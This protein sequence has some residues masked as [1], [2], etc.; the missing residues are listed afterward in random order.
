MTVLRTDPDTT[1]ALVVA[2]SDAD[3]R[4]ILKSR[5]GTGTLSFRVQNQDNTEFV[6]GDV[7]G[8]A[9]SNNATLFNA[10]AITNL[11]GTGGT[12]DALWVMKVS[13]GSGT[14]FEADKD[15]WTF[16][17][18]NS[19]E[20]IVI[21]DTL[22]LTMVLNEGVVTNPVAIAE[23]MGEYVSPNG[24]YNPTTPPGTVNVTYMNTSDTPFKFGKQINS[25]H[26][27][28]NY[29][30][31]AYNP[32]LVRLHD[33][34]PASNADDG[35]CFWAR[36]AQAGPHQYDKAR[37]DE[38]IQAN[39]GCPKNLLMY[40]TPKWAVSEANKQDVRNRY[41][42]ENQYGQISG[43]TRYPSY[44]YSGH[45]AEDWEN[46]LGDY[47]RWIYRPVNELGPGGE[48]G[49]GYTPEQIP[50][51]EGDNEQKF[52][53]REPNST[54]RWWDFPFAPNPP[55]SFNNMPMTEM[56]KKLRVMRS[57]APAEVQIWCGGW[58]GDYTGKTI[59]N[60][61]SNIEWSFFQALMLTSDGAGGLAIDHVDG[62]PFHPYMYN[63]DPGR[64]LQELRGYREQ[65]EYL[66]VY[67]NRPELANLPIYAN[68]TGHENTSGV[69][70]NYGTGSWAIDNMPTGS[71]PLGG[72]D[73]LA[74]NM[75]LSTMY[76]AI[77]ASRMKVHGITH[78]KDSPNTTTNGTSNGRQTYGCPSE[79]QTLINMINQLNQLDGE[80]IR[81]G[82]EI[83]STNLGGAQAL[84][85]ECESGLILEQAL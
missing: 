72:Y 84:W 45:E 5:L 13:N 20:A 10:V 35:G 15:C 3:R 83:N 46:S 68:E 21:T 32:L 47:I 57:A 58:E 41:G 63:Y 59:T 50:I 78:Y 16:A 17:G 62:I 29:V 61:G 42:Q 30:F 11:A 65:L 55:R 74:K 14:Y 38:A 37:F 18:P 64:V 34:F 66:A 75:A 82:Y 76:V 52:G 67:L 48:A 77:N 4:T 6:T 51:L 54:L 71:F 27:S 7:L 2:A 56:A 19:T 24:S 79:N 26:K 33:W 9:M 31:D 69:D 25:W 53:S 60:N 81:Q 23:S 43:P 39:N 40:L 49:G 12:P 28:N 36:I 85:L 44:P 22:F 8:S 73:T 70:G 1:A 80:V